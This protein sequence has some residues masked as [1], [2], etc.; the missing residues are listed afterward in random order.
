[1]IQK[2]FR[3]LTRMVCILTNLS[4]RLTGMLAEAV[5][6]AV[7]ELGPKQERQASPPVS[8]SR[9]TVAPA[10]PT[11]DWDAIAVCEAGG[12]GLWSLTTTG[13]GYFFALQFDPDTWVAYGGDPAWLNSPTPPP[14]EEQI[15][16]AERVLAGQGPGAWPRCFQW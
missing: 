14:R 3:G 13:N 11:A 2:F 15:A 16:V 12:H 10:V 1:M 8:A 5:L 6:A 4:G 7:L 9:Q